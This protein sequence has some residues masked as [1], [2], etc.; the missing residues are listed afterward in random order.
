M[1]EN[2]SRSLTIGEKCGTVALLSAFLL[3]FVSVSVAVFPLLCFLLLCCMAPFCPGWSFYLP[4]ISRGQRTQQRGYGNTVALTFDDGPSPV[5]TP[6]LLEL[7]A[8]YELP[9]TFFVVAAQ[10]VHH[11]DLLKKIID[12]GHTVGNHSLDHDNLLMLRGM[13]TLKKNIHESQ[14][15]LKQSGVEPLV[16]RPPVGITNPY[17]RDVL[18]EEGLV[19][20]NFSCRAFDR[21]NRNV[22]NL[23]EKIVR[24]LHPGDI[25]MLHDLPVYDSSKTKEWIGELEILFD[26]LAREYQIVPLEQLIKQPVMR[27]IHKEPLNQ[28]D[29]SFSNNVAKPTL[30]AV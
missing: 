25:I 2:H 11:P 9:A 29:E 27:F 22:R 14:E 30:P 16:F 1:D 13:D 10:V 26:T 5:S 7:L 8:R 12:A 17:L 24:R 6:I 21:G 20:V 28:P 19:A 18:A 4:V 23:S 15:I 3:S